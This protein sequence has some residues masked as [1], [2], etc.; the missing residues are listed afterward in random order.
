MNPVPL[1]K[2]ELAFSCRDLVNLDTLSKSDPQIWVE[3]RDPRTGNYVF[4]GRTE[5]IKNNLNPNFQ[6]RIRV[7]YYFEEV[8]MM[9]FTIADIDHPVETLAGQ[10]IIGE[11]ILPL[12]DIVGSRSQQATRNIVHP[13]RNKSGKLIVTA[14]EIGDSNMSYFFRAS[15][16]HLDKKDFLGKS[17]PFLEFSKQKDGNWI[18]FHRTEVIKQTVNPVWS[19]FTILG[20]KMTNNGDPTTPIKVQCFDWDSDNKT[21]FIGEFI[22]SLVELEH[23]REFNLINPKKQAKKKKYRNSGVI[24][25]DEFNPIRNYSF[26]DYI[27]G[28]TQINL[29]VAVDY[30]ASNGDP[31]SPQSL[32]YFQP[33]VLNQYSQVIQ[34]VGN[35]LVAYDSDNMIPAYGFGARMPN[36]QVSHCFHINGNPSNPEVYGIEGV[37]QAYQASLASGLQLYGPTNFAE[38]I[39]TA[40]DISGQMHNLNQDVQSYLILLIITDGEITDMGPTLEEV[41][42]M[43]TSHT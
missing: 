5:M 13:V 4:L 41:K 18:V 33:G 25:L 37:L 32:H 2:I 20:A 40:A 22:T 29:M 42:V 21:D 11:V 26:L 28:G 1:S 9:K 14:E 16:H 19:P 17:D 6:T 8:Q 30:T 27:V 34:A 12:S 15:G 36:G 35:I 10:D 38:I 31:S 24:T 7:D 39:H 23:Q 43:L 3:M